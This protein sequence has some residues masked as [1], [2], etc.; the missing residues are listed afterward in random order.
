MAVLVDIPLGIL[1]YLAESSPCMMAFCR[2]NMG[3]ARAREYN[4]PLVI[5]RGGVNTNSLEMSQFSRRAML[6]YMGG[7]VAVIFATEINPF[8]HCTSPVFT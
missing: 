4:G 2:L 3:Q 5:S 7:L 8:S 6:A 1:Q